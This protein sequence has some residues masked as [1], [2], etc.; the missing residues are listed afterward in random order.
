M[1][2]LLAFALYLV[3]GIFFLCF[4]VWPVVITV[5][6][7]FLDESGAFTLSYL[8]LVFSDP[9]YVEGLAN[10][11]IM[12]VC[13]TVLAILL[14][15]PLALLTDRYRFPG[16]TL[17]S[18]LILLPLILPPFVGAIGI[19]QIL[20]KAGVLNTALIE[21]GWM[22]AE[23]P[24]DWIGDSQ[25]LGVV[26][27]NALHLYPII[28]LNV[29]AALA[30]L[31][32]AMEEAAQSLG[33]GRMARFFRVTL[34]LIMPG[35][36]AGGTI[37]FIWA[38]TELGVPLMFDYS[39][40]TSVQIF[41]GLKDLSGNPTPYAL[42]VIMLLM[43]VAMFALSKCVFGPR[44]ASVAM[45]SKATTG[46]SDRSPGWFGAVLCTSVFALVTV[47]AVL[48]HVAV[49]LTSLSRDWYATLVPN[50]W[51]LAAYE[52]ALGHPLTLLSIKNSLFYASLATLIDVLLG[53]GIAYIVV[54]TRFPG[55]HLLDGMAMMPLA[56]PGL[57][58]AFGYLAM[59]REGQP[60]DFLM[61]GEDP[62]ILLVVAY[63]VRRLPYV[64]RSAVAGFQQTSV[65][66]EDAARDLGARPFKA[67]RKIT[68]P[69]IAANLIAGG[70]FAFAFAMLEVSDSLILA[71]KQA[72]YPITTAMY[73]L[74]NALG[75]GEKL[76]SALGVW[77]M[78]F[79]G[80][81]LIAVGLLLGRKMGAMFRI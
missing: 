27:M 48:P 65:E 6:E 70:L 19:K 44:A 4:F 51:T 78:L 16:K 80:V 8:G 55:R 57:V 7:A 13:S 71:T 79:L 20:G 75:N 43:A 17:F 77:A 63:A 74:F 81:T 54:R 26:V 76:A 5:G 37:V 50:E 47:V 12:G 29:T 21:W 30:N 60:F 34:P 73:A 56:V 61:L 58:L 15:V 18:S 40:V 2:R 38:F 1:A 69:L 9:I 23:A 24:I 53:L 52:E 45:G 46:R 14:A 25:L 66:L 28:F 67:F 31:D 11:L 32:P 42:V 10:S 3:T 62:V 35:L 68:L 64:V 39:R 33:C 59:T 36:F 22:S 41:N 49:I 72:Y